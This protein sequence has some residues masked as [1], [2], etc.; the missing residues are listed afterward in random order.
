M[1]RRAVLAFPDDQG[2]AQCRLVLERERYVEG[3]P[4][5]AAWL[6]CNP[7]TADALQDDPT[8]GRVIHHSA[9]AGCARSLVGNVWPWR[10]PYPRDLWAAIADGR[11]T[12]AMRAA[13]LE[14]LAMIGGQ[15]D[16]HVV[17]FG[18]DPDRRLPFDVYA[19]LE[20]FSAGFTVPLYCLGTTAD[21]KP[22]HPLA[23]GKHAIP[24]NAQLRLWL[25]PKA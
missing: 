11:L 13:N 10:S 5:T 2:V 24:N 18:A 8:A 1:L 15:A 3:P 6:M 9:N 4:R 12:P 14:A 23:R 7:S 19:A 25:G 16:I 22:L 21:D 17:A 20:A